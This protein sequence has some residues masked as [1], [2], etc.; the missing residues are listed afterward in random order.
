M[1]SEVYK[2]NETNCI[3]DAAARIKKREAQGKQAIRHLRA[4]ELQSTLRLTVGFSNSCCEVL[5]ICLLK[6]KIEIKLT[7]ISLS[8]LPSTV[9]LYL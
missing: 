2:R 9:L 7:V 3:L 1:K 8:L 5:Q 4:Q 6:I